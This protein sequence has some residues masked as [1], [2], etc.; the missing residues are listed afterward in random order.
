[1]SAEIVPY[2]W[3]VPSAAVCLVNPTVR[4]HHTCS[5]KKTHC[6]CS[7]CPGSAPSC[8]SALSN[9]Q[10]GACCDGYECCQR[11]CSTCTTC[12]GSGKKRH[13]SSHSCHCHCSYSVSDSYCKVY[14]RVRVFCLRAGNASPHHCAA[15]FVLLLVLL[16]VLTQIVCN[17]CYEDDL[18]VSYHDAS[19]NTHQATYTVR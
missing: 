3:Y 16:F 9:Q 2:T 4:C 14:E 8:S 1:V 10:P 19:G 17:T 5:C 15:P 13:C 7:S 18:I 12:T 11:V 6:S